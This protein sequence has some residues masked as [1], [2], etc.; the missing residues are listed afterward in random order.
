M[1]DRMRKQTEL[2]RKS[3]EL[4]DLTMARGSFE[5]KIKVRK[6]QDELYKQFEFY[7]NLNKAI[8][9]RKTK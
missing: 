4:R 9:K 7:K 5:Q 8:D 6:K 1:A 2:Y 3:K